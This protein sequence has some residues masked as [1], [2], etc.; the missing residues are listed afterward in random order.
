MTAMLLHDALAATADRL[1]HKTAVAS[2]S[3]R[4]TYAQLQHRS[5]RRSERVHRE[6]RDRPRVVGDEGELV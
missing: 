2:G 6:Q 5:P 3:E 4:L 1:P